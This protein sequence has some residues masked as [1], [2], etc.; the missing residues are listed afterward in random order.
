MH[1]SSNGLTSANARARLL[2]ASAVGLLL[3]LAMTVAPVGAAETARDIPTEAYTVPGLSASAEILVDSWGVPHIYAD[4]P[5]DAFLVQGFNAARDR[6]WQ[7]D[8]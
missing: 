3:G 2:A 1:R 4:D 8:L 6:L 7:I 5:Y